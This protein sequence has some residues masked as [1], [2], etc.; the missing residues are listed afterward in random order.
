M[1]PQITL[2]LLFG[3]A[4]TWCWL[5]RAK[6]TSGFFRIQMLVTLG[7]SVLALL[8]ASQL[9]GDPTSRLWGLTSLRIAI[10]CG[11]AVSFLGSVLWTL[12]RRSGGTRLAFVLAALFATVL[13]AQ[14]P[15]QSL[16]SGILSC[17]GE[18]SSGWLLGG[19][20]AAMLLGHWYL[21]APMMS[22]DPLT[23]A[24]RLLL[25][26]VILRI[27]VAVVM[28]SSQYSQISLKE[29]RI[30]LILQALAGLAAPLLIAFAVTRILK[31][32]NTQSATGVLFAAV[33]L[34]FIGES[35]G[36]LLMHEVQSR[37]P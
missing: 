33:I 27:V 16:G 25:A 4:L 26:A 29:H 35:A 3:M 21:T 7:L 34:I 17:L 10:G 1:I 37:G 24:N 6:V 20:V 19:A 14:L 13:S 28:L 11:A 12:E 18:W 5:P 2:R 15:Q 22:L 30:W 32:R 31:Y 23:Q 36:S 9:P 8:T